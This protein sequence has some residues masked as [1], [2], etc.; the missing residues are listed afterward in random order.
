MSPTA[1]GGIV[2]AC[3][4]VGILLGMWLRSRLPGQH[5]NNDTQSS[6]KEVNGLIATMTALIL[7]LVTASAQDS[8]TKIGT[9][10]EHTAADV[11]ALDRLLSRFGP[12]T[13]QIRSDLR[14]AV[15][16]RLDLF[17]PAEPGEMVARPDA[18]PGH[19]IE[20]IGTM[21]AGL[22]ART[23]NQQWLKS[24][25]LD[26]TESLLAA[27]WGIFAGQGPAIPNVFLVI[28]TFWLASAFAGYTL[29][30]PRNSTMTGILVVGAFSVAC[31]IFLILELGSPFEGRIAVSGDALRF[32][33]AHLGQ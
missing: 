23:A 28:V 29:F 8:Y 7:G 16:Q 30:S 15:K 6:V 18:R 13:A 14:S 9:A 5:L 24:R 3:I 27:R 11:I 10:V 20:R 1:T 33:L 22:E 19:E 26:S 17:W 2:F 4:I 25:A 32:A 12:E 31:V 21:I